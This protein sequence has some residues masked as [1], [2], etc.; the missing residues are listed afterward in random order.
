MARLIINLL[1][2]FL[3]PM[4]LI[5]GVLK[6]ILVIL[7]VFMY[8]MIVCINKYIRQMVGNSSNLCNL[9]KLSREKYLWEVR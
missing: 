2:S 7:I 6:V 9:S 3:L 1:N 5:E 4:N 8:M